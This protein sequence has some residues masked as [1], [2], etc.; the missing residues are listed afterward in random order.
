MALKRC[1]E[2]GRLCDVDKLKQQE[3]SLNVVILFP[4]REHLDL[5]P[6]YRKSR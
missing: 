6:V 4:S 1:Q 3:E 2:T 5:G